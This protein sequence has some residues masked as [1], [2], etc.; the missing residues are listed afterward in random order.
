[1]LEPARIFASFLDRKKL[2]FTRPRRLILDTVFGL[3]GHFDIEYLYDLIHQVSKDVS[4]ATVYRT[5]PLLLEAGLVQRSLRSEARDKFEHI[6]GHP[7]HAHWICRNC[8]AVLETGL[9]EFTTLVNDKA[10]SQN[11]SPENVGLEI[12]GLCWKCKNSENESH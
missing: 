8:G 12:T 6:Y 10:R 4:R 7:R 11:F 9:Q 5:I 3:H 1:M 2:K